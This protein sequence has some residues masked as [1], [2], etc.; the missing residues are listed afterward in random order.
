MDYGDQTIQ[1]QAVILPAA[2]A[3]LF[4]YNLATAT[5]TVSITGIGFKPSRIVFQGSVGGVSTFWDGSSCGIGAYYN[6]CT[7]DNQLET[8]DS[9]QAN[10]GNCI[11]VVRSSGNEQSGKIIS[12]DSD[13]F[14]I[15]WIKT[16]TPTGTLNVAFQAFK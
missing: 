10:S 4:I 1:D 3:S 6:F 5:G 9:F 16:G 15:S 13:G 14:T 7:R 11:T 8:T 2:Y 12:F